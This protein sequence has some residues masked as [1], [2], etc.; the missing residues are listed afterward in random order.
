MRH[1]N[2]ILK[3]R[4]LYQRRYYLDAGIDFINDQL[5]GPWRDQGYRWMFTKCK[6]RGIPIKKKDVRILLSLLEPIGSQVCQT[7]RLRRRQYFPQGPNFVWHIDSYNKLKPYGIWT[8]G[9]IDGFSHKIIWLRAAFTNSDSKVIEG[10]FVESVERCGGCPRLIWIDLSTE[11]V[12]VRDLQL[13][14]RR[15]DMEIS[16]EKLHHRSKYRESENWE[17]VWGDEKGRNLTLDH[18][19]GR[20]EG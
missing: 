1:L 20:T 18:A 19:F 11:N 12:V 2:R 3:A 6:Q 9:C 8:N 5:Q 13:Y 4:F 17:L 16:G 14:L 15:N 10:Y 7:R